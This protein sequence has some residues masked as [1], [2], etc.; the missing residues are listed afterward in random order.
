MLKPNQYLNIALSIILAILGNGCTRLK[1]KDECDILIQSLKEIQSTVNS[2]SDRSK[3]E[4]MPVFFLGDSKNKIT[5]QAQLVE[6]I[7]VRANRA[8]QNLAKLA[9]DSKMVSQKI[10]QIKLDAIA[11]LEQ[12]QNTSIIDA[13]NYYVKVIDGRTDKVNKIREIIVS[14]K[15]IDN[16]PEGIND[17][18]E[19]LKEVTDI[20]DKIWTDWRELFKAETAISWYCRGYENGEFLINNEHPSF[21]NN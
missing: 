11:A 20:A 8:E 12:K 4:S 6:T 19:S 21:P 5:N 1:A 13:R 15:K 16:S 9:D 3:N 2:I 17:W 10:A 18:K 14:L 7:R